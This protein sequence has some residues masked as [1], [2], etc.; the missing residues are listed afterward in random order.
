MSY[1]YT[2]REGYVFPCLQSKHLSVAWRKKL[3]TTAVGEAKDNIHLDSNSR[4]SEASQV[5]A[6][7]ALGKEAQVM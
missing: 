6:H 2:H 1:I 4:G 3:K 7:L 5:S